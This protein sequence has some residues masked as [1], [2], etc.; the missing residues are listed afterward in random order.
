M[1]GQHRLAMLLLVALSLGGCAE[2]T[3]WPRLI[4]QTLYNSGRYVCTQS[5][6]CDPGDASPGSSSNRQ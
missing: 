1:T 3:D 4:G 6:N 5:S 2:T